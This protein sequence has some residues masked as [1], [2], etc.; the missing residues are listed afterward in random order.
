MAS[1]DALET[2]PQHHLHAY[3]VARQLAVAAHELVRALPRGYGKLADQL[4]RCSV[5]VP[6][7]VAEGANRRSAAQ[8][9]QRYVEALGETGECAAAAEVA[10]D[11]GLVGVTLARP[12]WEL[13]AREASMLKGLVKRYE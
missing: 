6:L 3:Q 10:L 4:R 11:L 1:R 9:R 7:L 8:R 12:V 5:A 13:A 2:F